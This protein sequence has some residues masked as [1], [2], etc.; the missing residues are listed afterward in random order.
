MSRDGPSELPQHYGDRTSNGEM[1]RR[2]D[3][4]TYKT[5]GRRF[6]Y[7]PER[8]VTDPAHDA[9]QFTFFEQDNHQGNPRGVLRRR[10]TEDNDIPRRHSIQGHDRTMSAGSGPIITI[11]NS[12]KPPRTS[13]DGS[14]QE[15]PTDRHQ[16]RDDFHPDFY[17]RSR[18]PRT[19]RNTDWNRQ[20][21]SA[22]KPTFDE[23]RGDYDLE[24]GVPDQSSLTNSKRMRA[25]NDDDVDGYNYEQQKRPY[26]QSRPG[27]NSSQKEQELVLRLPWTQWMNSDFKNRKSSSWSIIH[28]F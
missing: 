28:P 22:S 27:Y 16:R 4:P 25:S 9:D 1:A 12:R 14:R 23:T 17:E 21:G 18:P 6:D 15:S 5:P 8:A 20:P 7:S 10:P 2:L 13:K 3:S 19:H 24:K 11:D 26:H